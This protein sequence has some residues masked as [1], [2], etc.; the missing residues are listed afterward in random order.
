MQIY[1]Y[2]QFQR[3]NYTGSDCRCFKSTATFTKN[4]VNR[5]FCLFKPLHTVR[6]T[7]LINR[8]DFLKHRLLTHIRVV[9][10]IV[11]TKLKVYT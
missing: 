8:V 1:I 6:K 11:E 7:R 2:T 3:Q 4:N 10:R 9:F 5:N